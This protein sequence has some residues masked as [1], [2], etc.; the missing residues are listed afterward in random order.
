M[1][2]E[3]IDVKSITFEEIDNK[4]RELYKKT[5]DGWR[6]LVCDYTNSSPKSSSMRMHVE[7]HLD[8]LVYTCNLCSKEFKSRNVLGK[9]KSMDH[10]FD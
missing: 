7:T 5:D 8:G 1:G 9:H 3:N 6:C 4:R 2:V 10:K